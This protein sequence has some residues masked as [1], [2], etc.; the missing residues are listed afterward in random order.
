METKSCQNCKKDF[1]IEQD[2]FLFYEK[3][4]VPPPTFC[5]EC[6]LQRRLVWMKGLD[7][8]KRKCDLCGEVKISMYHPDAPYVVY[9]T[10]CWWGDG[11]D[12]ADYSMEYDSNRTF[13]EQWNE[14]Y[15]KTPVFGLST[16]KITTELSPY[17]NHVG[18]SKHSYLIFYSYLVEDSAYGFEITNSKNIYN[19]GT[20]LNSENC[21]DSSNVYKSYNIVSSS[22]NT[23]SCYDCFFIRDCEGCHHCFGLSNGKNQSYVFL[24]EQLT[25]EKYEES[26]NNIDMGSYSQY[27]QWKEKVI[28]YFKTISPKPVWETLSQNISGSYIFNSKNCHNCFD[29]TDCEDSKFLMLIKIGKVK[30]SYDYTDWGENVELLYECMTVGDQAQNVKFSHDCG[31]GISNI[32]YSK[33]STGS[34]YN[35]GCI[36]IKKSDYCILNK[37]YSKEE[38]FELRKKIIKDMDINPYRSI[39]GHTYKY[40]EF[41]PPE[42]SPHSYNDS[43]AS[44]VF[45]L[46]ID[47]VISKGLKWYGGEKKEYRVTIQTV[48]IPDNTAEVD[49]TILNEV[50]QCG[51]CVRG[52]KIISQELQFLQQHHLPLPRQC[53]F[54]RVWE[55]VDK[56]VDNM[57]QV[58]RNCDKCGINFIT[59]Y[60]KEEA[61]KIFCKECYKKE[62]L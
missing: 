15:H 3:I 14:L 56:C 27:L 57:K 19:C 21:F 30:D 33:L 16:D 7:L 49:E 25:K 35:F 4:K 22:G 37:K 23:R 34:S 11:W 9:C 58:E 32:E 13:F 36:S 1:V 62:F 54:C 38:Y 52:F 44:R 46:T 26:V 42:F 24:G 5:P 12:P 8:F 18:N 50:L 20:I 51:T 61:L 41:L 40:G 39:E 31:H 29:V 60:S 28:N 2:D 48:D 55:K 10:K 59:H 47:T 53:P 43:F 6:R 17:T 45:P